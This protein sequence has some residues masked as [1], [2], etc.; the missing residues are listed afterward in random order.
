MDRAPIRV[1]NPNSSVS[2]TTAMDA[3]L[4]PLKALSG[5][6]IVCETLAEGPPGVQSEA[7]IAQVTG[8]LLGLAQSRPASALV[9]AC[10]SDP[11][12]PLLREAMACP[13]FGI[14][15]S[16]YLAALNLGQRFGVISILPVSVK[17]HLRQIR[18]LGLGQRLAGDLALGLGVAELADDE[19]MVLERLC[20]VAN[21]IRTIKWPEFSVD[22]A[23]E[24]LCEWY[25]AAVGAVI[26]CAAGLIMMVIDQRTADADISRWAEANN[27]SPKS[28]YHSATSRLE[29]IM[30]ELL[31]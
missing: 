19:A 21:D 11:G 23:A 17:R 12:V 6:E 28:G 25:F 30:V 14:G 13:V 3:A 7:H 24:D 20:S 2:V 18:A 22:P 29:V 10:F 27:A 1:I 31:S 8:P 16:A 9:V 4:T 5:P 26:L 15:E